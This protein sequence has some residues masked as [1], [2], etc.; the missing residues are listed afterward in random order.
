MIEMHAV[1]KNVTVN[2]ELVYNVRQ[3]STQM[4]QITVLYNN[5]T[6]KLTDL[7]KRLKYKTNL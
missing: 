2:K 1:A 6:T 4:S 3:N 7:N 5:V